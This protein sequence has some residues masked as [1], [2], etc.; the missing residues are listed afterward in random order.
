MTP[1]SKFSSLE[2]EVHEQFPSLQTAISSLRADFATVATSSAQIP[3][4]KTELATLNSKISTLSSNPLLS[5]A[6]TSSSQEISDIH[7]LIDHLTDELESLRPA[8]AKDYW[9]AE[10][11]SSL[12]LPSSLSFPSDGSL[13]IYTSRLLNLYPACTY[14]GQL[15]GFSLP[16]YFSILDFQLSHLVKNSQNKITSFSFSSSTK[17]SALHPRFLWLQARTL[18]VLDQKLFF[19]AATDY[20]YALLHN[21]YQFLLIDLDM[22]SVIPTNHNGSSLYTLPVRITCF[23]SGSYHITPGGISYFDDHWSPHFTSELLGSQLVKH[24]AKHGSRQDFFINLTP[25][26]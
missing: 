22:K 21:T 20:A 18:G 6:L 3:S 10:H 1:L 2:H 19:L 26:K 8:P 23:P 9:T 5:E 17:F 4:L 24:Y 13:T 16:S 11:F 15:T 14:Y 12:K 7:S 25:K